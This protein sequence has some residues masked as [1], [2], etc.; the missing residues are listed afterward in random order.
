M[1]NSDQTC[2][3]WVAN[4]RTVGVCKYEC[5]CYRRINWRCDAGCSGL[6]RSSRAAGRA[7][8]RKLP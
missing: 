1:S 7:G 6:G 5:F 4:M 3:A 2:A 8:W